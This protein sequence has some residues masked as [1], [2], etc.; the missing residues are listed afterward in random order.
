MAG[1]S[2]FRVRGVTCGK[3]ERVHTW[4]KYRVWR[5]GLRVKEEYIG[6]CDEEGNDV[7]SDAESYWSKAWNQWEQQWEQAYTRQQAY[8]PPPPERAHTP[9]EILGVSYTATKE[10][11]TKAYRTLVKQYH[12]DL[13]PSVDQKIIAEINVAYHVLT[14]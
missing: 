6:K 11:I 4:Y 7:S 2:H 1:K 14:H 5:E 10:Q 8:K 13:N 3:C 9:Y 12:P